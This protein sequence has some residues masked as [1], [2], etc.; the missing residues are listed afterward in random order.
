MAKKRSLIRDENIPF[1]GQPFAF[2]AHTHTPDYP[3]AFADI[4]ARDALSGTQ[5]YEGVIAYVQSD[6]TTYQLRG[7]IDNTDWI[8]LVTVTGVAS[9]NELGDIGVNSHVAIDTHIADATLHFTE[10][11]ISITESQISDLQAYSLP[12]HDHDLVYLAIAGTAA[13]ADALSSA[14]STIDVSAAAQPLIGQVLTAT[15]HL[16]ATWQFPPGGGASG[17]DIIQTGAPADTFVA[18]F[19]ADKNLSGDAGLTWITASSRL[20]LTGTDPRFRLQDSNSTGVTMQNIIEFYDSTVLVAEVGFIAGA[21]GDLSLK[22][23][24]GNIQLDTDGSANVVV[25]GDGN[26]A[27][28][29]YVDGYAGSPVDGSFL[30]WVTANNRAEFTVG[31]SGIEPIGT[32]ANNEIVVF[33][34]P[35]SAD[36]DPNFTWDQ[37]LLTVDGFTFNNANDQMVLGGGDLTNPGMSINGSAT[38]SPFINLQQ[39]GTTRAIFR[40][41]D[42]SDRAEL[43]SASDEITLRPGNIDTFTLTSTLT[44]LNTDVSLLQDGYQVIDHTVPQIRFQENDEGLD[45]KNTQWVQE[46]GIFDF[47]IADDAYANFYSWLSYTRSGTGAGIQVDEVTLNVQ[48]VTVSGN[49][50]ANNIPSP[51]LLMG[52]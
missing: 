35:T 45:Q 3:P 37:V 44:T 29:G 22:N 49:L 19:T 14:T 38:A 9:H 2:V 42:A 47:N 28:G 39:A 20:N 24:V 52:A 26:I 34:G 43:S 48:D 13:I 51:Y 1:A 16:A 25:S 4:A 32:P 31:P 6:Q 12:S 33:D 46:N 8:T 30:I 27:I 21:A 7:G 10:A 36:G 50:V 41:N 11:S 5:R 15:S 23:T 17:G 18:Y 40:F